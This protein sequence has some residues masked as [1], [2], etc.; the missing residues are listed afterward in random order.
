MQIGAADSAPGYFDLHLTYPRKG[1]V[2]HLFHTHILPPVPH[3]CFHFRTSISTRSATLDIL[4]SLVATVSA[5]ASR[6]LFAN[7]TCTHASQNPLSVVTHPIP[8]T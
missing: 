6:G 5:F 3:C 2:M 7:V 8:E 4:A 1:W